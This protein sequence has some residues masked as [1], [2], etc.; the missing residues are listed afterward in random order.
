[1]RK[2]DKNSEIVQRL[3][4]IILECDPSVREARGSI[5]KNKDALNY[6]QG[7][8][9]KYGLTSSKNF[10]TFHSMV[11]YGTPALMDELKARLLTANFQKGCVNFRSLTDFPEEAFSE[12]LRKSA[13]IDFASMI[14]AARQNKLAGVRRA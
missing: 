8:V 5:M 13:Q 10:I 3:R 4:K 14:T 12:H 11:L 6:F 7:G 9:F 2:P 1:M